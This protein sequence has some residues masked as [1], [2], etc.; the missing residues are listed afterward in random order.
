MVLVAGALLGRM[1]F[2]AWILFVPLWL[3]FSY[4]ICAFSIWSPRGWL[5]K[6][7]LIDYS[8]ALSSTFLRGSLVSSRHIACV[9][10]IMHVGPRAMKDRERFLPNNI[11]LMLAWAGLVWIGWSGFNGGDPYTASVDASLVVLNTHVCTT[12]SLITWL[13]LDILFFGKPSVIGATQ[14]MIT[15]LVCITP[16][17]D[18]ILGGQDS[19]HYIGL[20]YGIFMGR[21][22]EGFRQ[23]G[24]QLLG[25][26]FVLV[27]NVSITCTVCRLV[28]V[29]VPLRLHEDEL[30]VGDDAVHGEVAYALWSDGEKLETTTANEPFSFTFQ[31]NHEW[32]TVELKSSSEIQLE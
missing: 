1:N 14:G 7:G 30:Q 11:V 10:T 31:K 32:P 19:Q 25:I 24:V 15:G 17:A 26:A 16:T 13:F 2:H 6:I 27:L 20:A 22:K 29:I 23:M 8:V 21:P 9:I 18:T 5:F 12:M 3:T 28:N 4:T